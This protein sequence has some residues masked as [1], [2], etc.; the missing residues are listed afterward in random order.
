MKERVLAALVI[1]SSL[2]A[3]SSGPAS[4]QDCGDVSIADMNWASAQIT[5]AVDAFILSAGFGCNVELSGTDAIPALASM[6]D[7]G[8]PDLIPELWVNAVLPQVDQAVASGSVKLAAEIM[9]DGGL[10]GWWIPSY[11]AEA[12]PEITSIADAL[13]R[14]DLFP[15]PNDTSKAAVHNCPVGWDCQ[16]AMANLFLAHGAMDEGFELINEGSAA[17]LDASIAI[18]N[19]AGVG[20]LGYYWAPTSM[21]GRYQMIKLDDAVAHDEQ[22]WE[23]C[24]AV[25]ECSDPEPNAWP[26]SSAYSVVSMSFAD[27]ETAAMNY[28]STRQWKNDMLST[29]LAWRADNQASGEEVAQHFLVEFESLWTQWVPAEVTARIKLALIKPDE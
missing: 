7:V 4:A 14:P 19:K 11:I 28:V 25:A 24:T 2:F 3:G 6:R 12:H 21:L 13:A 1:V 18:A 29:L 8:K 27:N 16:V 15:S 20:W 26:K 17:G 10:Q 22:Q 23:A 5:T 9:A